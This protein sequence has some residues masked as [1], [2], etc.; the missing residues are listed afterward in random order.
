ME[1]YNTGG[2]L[3][4]YWFLGKAMEQH[5]DSSL[6]NNV[7]PCFNQTFSYVSF[8]FSPLPYGYEWDVE[9]KEEEKRP[10][11]NKKGRIVTH[12]RKPSS[13]EKRNTIKQLFQRNQKI[14]L[15]HLQ[16][17]RKWTNYRK[18]LITLFKVCNWALS[19]FCH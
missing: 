7:L 14:L 18:F 3:I 10:G 5:I 12:G 15:H 9:T 2:V 19:V 1:E 13:L 11:T 8:G 16:A 17:W 6:Y 4:M